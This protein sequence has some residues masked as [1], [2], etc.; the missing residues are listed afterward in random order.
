[1][2]ATIKKL[3]AS[4]ML[5]IFF[6]FSAQA[7]TFEPAENTTLQ[8]NGWFGAFYGKGAVSSETEL[9]SGDEETQIEFRLDRVI[10]KDLSTFFE[11]EFE[12]YFLDDSAR[13]VEYDVVDTNGITRTI[14]EGSS[15]D[16]NNVDVDDIKIGINSSYGQFLITKN[17]DDPFEQYVAEPFDSINEFLPISEA[18]TSPADDTQIQYTSPAGP[19]GVKIILG[20]SKNAD[21]MDDSN[22]ASVVL[23][24]EKGNF[25][26][27]I[28]SNETSDENDTTGFTFHYNINNLSIRA[29]YAKEEITSG[30]G[31]QIDKD[32]TGIGFIYN[33]PGAGTFN[34]AT[35]KVD[36]EGEDKRTEVAVGYKQ[37]LVTGVTLYIE[38]RD[39]DIDAKDGTGVGVSFDF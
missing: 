23:N 28:G 10:S 29:L 2:N 6:V 33:I 39:L 38:T 27:S 37:Q 31:E 30:G 25:G 20:L 26:F 22:K 4:L 7:V 34:A 13:T 3:L 11:I 16:S 36:E 12:S 21:D 35:Q 32:F 24:Y 9:T 14:K 1:M 17:T 15:N 18:G 19:S 5:S 8:I